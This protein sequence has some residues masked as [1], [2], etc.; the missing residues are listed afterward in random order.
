MKRLLSILLL[1]LF[2]LSGCQKQPE[3]NLTV[4]WDDIT[5]ETKQVEEVS[6]EPEIL[7][8]LLAV[9]VPATTERITHENGAELFS[10]TAQH[11]QLIL[12]DAVVAEKV[13][14]NFLNRVDAAR[15]DAE[16]IIAAAKYDYIEDD[17]WFP[18]YSQLVFSPTR[19]DHGVLSL[20]GMQNSYS[21]GN[22][23]MQNCTA[24]NYDLMTG[25]IL[26]LGSIMHA[27]ASKEDFIRI[28][29]QKLEDLAGEYNL[30]DNYQD[31]VQ[32]RLGGDENLYEDF[33]F[34]TTGLNFFFSPY[35]IAP[36]S[37]GYVTVEIP[38]HELPGLIYDGYFPEEREQI[39]GQM[40]VSA[41]D[42]AD[43]VNFDNMAEVNLAVGE[44]TFVA[45]PEGNV[46]DIR[47]D[48]DGD[49]IATPAYTVFAAF[50][51]SDRD[52]VVI[53]LEEDMVDKICVSY[54]SA[55]V[56][57]TIPLSN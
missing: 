20:F 13:V 25:D 4:P 22:H 7:K 56:V 36:Y 50:E 23:G 41:F 32:Y 2:M 47:V 27:E 3:P 40:H 52:A 44:S 54:A 43:A 37:A 38:Y 21:G 42:I 5:T 18:Y 55:N 1:L 48:V 10:F 19:I 9:S 8:E 12:P 11:M 14:L 26:T 49:N 31:G 16:S 51:M 24:V 17:V 6:A 30:F 53:N 15:A 35:E 57:N 39:N 33:F 28:V 46:E 29:T 34:T 45:Y